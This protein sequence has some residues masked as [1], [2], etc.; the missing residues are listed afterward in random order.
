MQIMTIRLPL[1]FGVGAVNCYLLAVDDG[2][3]LIDTAFAARGRLLERA[4]LAA[5]CAPGTLRLIVLTH[6]DFDHSGNAA[7][8]RARFAAPIAMHPGDLGMVQQGDLFWNRRM[9]NGLANVAGAAL[10][11]FGKAQRFTPDILLAE[12]DD[13]R[14]YGLDARVLWLPGHSQGS[15][16]V[17][18][19]AGHVFPGD[20]VVNH[21]MPV[22]GNIIDDAELAKA[23]LARLRALGHG[24][25]YPGHGQ[26]FPLEEMPTAL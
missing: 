3:V 22:A 14:P 16:A 20:L 23:S 9:G 15:I 24:T 11:G 4:M 7:R 2:Y 19:A 18:T 21:G 10:Y 26:P 25:V 6:G 8:L 5:G 17:H 13:L 12:G 1:P